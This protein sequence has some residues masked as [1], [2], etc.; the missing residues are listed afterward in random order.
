MSIAKQA[1]P[2]IYRLD[3]LVSMFLTDNHLAKFGFSDELGFQK[4]FIEVQVWDRASST[5]T[6]PPFLPPQRTPHTAEA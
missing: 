3:Q 1:E 5:I 6:V 4:N 2:K